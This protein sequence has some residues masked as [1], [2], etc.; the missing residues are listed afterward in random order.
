M[1]NLIVDANV[2]VG[3]VLRDRGRA[4]LANPNLKIYAGEKIIDETRYELQRRLRIMRERGRFSEIT[5]QQLL[6]AAN[7]A[8]NS[9]IEF[10]PESVY[11]HL[12]PEARK[13]IPRDPNDW[14]TVALALALPAAIWTEDYDFFGCGCPTWTTE[15]L[16]LQLEM[17]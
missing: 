13:R 1:M 6:T 3:E 16:M 7:L 5:E 10:V 8:I 11:A 4:F 9:Y 2:L 12:E 14:E 15:T 17:M